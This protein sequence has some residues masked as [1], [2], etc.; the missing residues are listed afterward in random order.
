MKRKVEVA[1]LV[2]LDIKLVPPEQLISICWMLSLAFLV[3]Q[4]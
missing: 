3:R 4:M 1:T 2:R